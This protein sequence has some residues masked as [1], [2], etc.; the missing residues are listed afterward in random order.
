MKRKKKLIALLGVLAALCVMT[1]I[2]GQIT[3]SP[4]DED[5]GE[6][7]GQEETAIAVAS[8]AAEDV[9]SLAVE[10]G[11]E[12]LALS[13]TDGEWMNAQDLDFPID[14]DQVSALLENLADVTASR[15]IDEPEA[16]SEYGLETPQKTVSV[17]L[18]DGSVQTF[19]FGDQNTLTSETY[20][21]LNGDES[22]VYLVSTDLADAFSCDPY[23]VVAMEVLPT[24]ENVLSLRA[25]REDGYAFTLRRIEDA[26]TLTSSEEA[27]WFLEKSGLT[28]AVDTAK[29]ESLYEQV[30]GLSWLSCVEAHADDAQKAEYGLDR[31]ATAVSLVWYGE[32]GEEQTFSLRIGA[33]ADGGT[34][35]SL[36]GSDMVYLISTS[37]ADALRYVTYAS[38]RPDAV[39]PIDFDTVSQIEITL[40]ESSMTLSVEKTLEEATAA[41]AEAEDAGENEEQA[42]STAS[43][44]DTESEDTASGEPALVRT[45]TSEGRELD[46]A[47]V[48]SLL[49]ALDALTASGETGTP[50]TDSPMISFTFTRPDEPI[51][52]VSLTI[53]AFDTDS[54]LVGTQEETCLLITREDAQELIERAQPLFT[55]AQSEEAAESEG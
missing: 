28:R 23:D 22:A 54:C 16:L 3:A 4:S 47:T 1:V 15:R 38:L 37:T 26:A 7:A 53:Y 17:T 46:T 31:A 19:A 18:S 5:T 8:V 43:D 27:L 44:S 40:G 45:Y 42:E 52:T 41:E 20:M 49:D 48:E 50:D 29:A 55:P 51:S 30:T 35:A 12:T 9:A 2:A 14:G 10:S 33:D 39:C 24:F 6:D 21:L 32:D 36:E 11:G 34:Y 25:S 13:R